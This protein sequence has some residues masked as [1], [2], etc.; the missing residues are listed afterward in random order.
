MTSSSSLY[1]TVTTQNASSTNSTSLYGGADTPIPDSSGNLIVRG[2]LYVLSGNILTTA[3]TGNVFPTNA[4]TINVGLAATTV[5]IGADS[6]TTTINNDLVVDGSFSAG[7]AQ[8]GNITIAVD[9]DNTI[10]TTTGDLVLDADTGVISVRADHLASTASTFFLLNTPTTI[11]A[12]DDATALS[13]GATTGTTTI[14]NNLTVGNDLTI[15]GDNVNLAS[16][17]LFSYDESGNRANR[18]EVQSTTGNSSGFRVIAPN[19]TTSANS[20]LTVFNTNDINNG[21]FIS[22]QANGSASAPFNIRTGTYASGVLSSSNDVITLIDGITT[23][24]TINPAGPTNGSDLTTKTYVDGVVADIPTYDTNVAPATGGVDLQ[25]REIDIPSITIVG[26]T[27]FLGGTNITISE[28]ASNE[29]TIDGTDLNTTYTQDASVTT[30]GANLNLVGSDASTD[31]IKFANGTNVTVTAT[32]ANTITIAATD[33][34]TTYTV[35]ATSTT[36]GANLNLTG[37]DAS[38]DSVAY[39]GSGATTVTRTDANTITISSTDNNT[40]Y[41]QDVSSTTGGANVNLNGSDASVDSVAY[42]GA[43]SVT[44]TATDA[45]TVTITGT[46]TNTTYTVDATST[47]GGANLN[48]TGSDASVDSVAYLG[49]GATTVTRTDANTITISSTDNNTT[50]TQDVSSTT[51][52]ANLNLVGSDASTDSV[53]FAGGT[54]VTVVAT[55]ASTMTINATDT[56]T[57]YDFAASATTGGA[58][59]TLTGSDA[60]TDTVKVSSGTGITVADVSATEISIT[61]SGV[62][63]LA[64]STGI[65]VSG[66]TGAVTVTNTGVTSAVA[67]TGIGVS[68]GTGA[69]TFTNTG[70]TS[71]AASTYLSVNSSTG[72]V[73][74]STNATSANTASTIVARDASGNFSAGTITANLANGTRVLGALTA[75]P[76]TTY[77]FPAPPLATITDNNGIDAVSSYNNSPTTLGNGAQGQFTHFFGDTFA[78]GN[79]GAVFSLRT[80]NGN[81]ETTGTIPFTGVAPVAPSAVTSTNVIGGLNFNGYATTGFTD[82]IG[83]QNQG[84]GFNAV[85]AGQIQFAPAETFADGTLTISGATITAVSRVNVAQTVTSVS[86]TRGQLTIPATLVGVGTAVVVTGTL[87]GTATGIGAGT[88]YVVANNGGAGTSTVITLSATVGGAPLTT[89]AGTVT[90]LTFT[91]QLIT[92]TYS[93][94]S[95]IPFGINA[96]V[97]VAN[98]TNVTTGTFMVVGS[99]TTTSVTIG[100]TSS[101]APTL[102]GTQSLSIPTVTNGGANFRV[103][104][105][106]TATP[107]NSGNRVDLINATTASATFRS[108]TFNFNTGAYG[109]TG[110]GVTGNKIVYNRVYGQFQYNTTVTPAATNTAAVFPLGTADVNNIATVG[111][112]S[113]LIPGATGAYNMQ[114]SIQVN[115]AD[116]GTEHTAYIWLRKNGTDVTG[117]MGRITVPK[118]GAT[119][120]AWNY[121]INPTLTT[122]YY[123]LAYAVDDLNITFPA[124]AATAFGPSTATIITT[125]VPIG[126]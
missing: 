108:D 36:G 95:Y 101:G 7:S 37:S 26:S 35:D 10:G 54:N 91:R 21:Q 124:F 17:T 126:A 98:F 105:F 113:R 18:P 122:D 56:N 44:V 2:D 33:T 99:P 15:N 67:G 118:G 76:S 68:A 14:N 69:V 70:V 43:G 58:N 6:G 82:Y 57:T 65:S 53:K 16:S 9:D 63:S 60:T 117:S 92:V 94:Q 1:G 30:G 29:I 31:T 40:T 88:Y 27:K 23:Y 51:G 100:A 81:S 75:T 5:N 11:T 28:T 45:S 87:T 42:K 102:P 38:V 93:A 62:T 55:D 59:L 109:N 116:N 66:S 104:A 22:V 13:M 52:G 24:A 120:S 34:N 107:L 12:F 90:G 20:N 73:T 19:A 77:T 121:V 39:L 123:E 32:D 115:N 84:G 25:L 86:G 8:Y 96:K 79:T 110:V 80:A 125:L 72:A 119:I 111:S 85:H 64:A 3:T 71:L 106:P 74:V 112:T 83:T 48:L 46:D 61:N 49:S 114:F 47:T 41:T 89:T 103:R 78:G 97:A 4:T 50:Y